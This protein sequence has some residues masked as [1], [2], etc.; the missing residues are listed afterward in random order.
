MSLGCVP[1]RVKVEPGVTRDIWPLLLCLLGGL[2]AACET[3]L[4]PRSAG[5]NAAD[6]ATCHADHGAE[7]AA[8]RHAQAGRSE[9]FVALRERAEAE[10]ALGGFC[11]GCHRPASDDGLDCLSCHAAVGSTG[12]GE[13]TLLLDPAGPVRGPTG[14]AASGAP[15]DLVQGD[16]LGAP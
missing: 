2:L 15:H 10:R 1:I 11:D 6:C 14:R 16:F 5:A 13:G 7:H 3:E 4:G 12:V 8:S 9:L